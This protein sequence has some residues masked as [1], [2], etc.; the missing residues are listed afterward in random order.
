MLHT[1]NTLM[2]QLDL[3]QMSAKR[4]QSALLLR[5]PS[6]PSEAEVV[7][8]WSVNA[9]FMPASLRCKDWSGNDH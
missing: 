2:R 6:K 9:V 8:A 3:K 4:S 5:C 1:G 7:W